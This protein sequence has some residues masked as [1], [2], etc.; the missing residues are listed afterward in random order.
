MFQNAFDC[1]SVFAS[2]P[3]RSNKPNIHIYAQTLLTLKF[4]RDLHLQFEAEEARNTGVGDGS[5]GTGSDDDAFS[6]EGAMSPLPET[7]HIRDRARALLREFAEDPLPDLG[8]YLHFDFGLLHGGGDG[9]DGLD[10]EG[11]VECELSASSSSSSSSSGARDNH[12]ENDVIVTSAPAWRDIEE[13]R[14]REIGACEDYVPV[15][16]LVEAWEARA[17]QVGGQYSFF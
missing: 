13:S 4:R 5:S 12:G 8:D 16:V 2:T 15:P 3:T 14:K 9:D 6:G 7:R 17:R 1:A 11:D 10:S